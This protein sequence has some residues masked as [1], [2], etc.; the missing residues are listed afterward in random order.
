[1]RDRHLTD[2]EDKAIRDGNRELLELV[3]KRDHAQFGLVLALAWPEPAPDLPTFELD[4]LPDFEFV[5]TPCGE[6]MAR[7]HADV[8][9]KGK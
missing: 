1:M 7:F 6:R 2:A 9:A 4:D 5:L 8:F 3:A